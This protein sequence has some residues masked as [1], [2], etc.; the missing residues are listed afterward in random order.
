MRARGPVFRRDSI[1]SLEAACESGLATVGRQ[2]EAAKEVLAEVRRMSGM[3]SR[4][5]NDQAWMASF[6]SA[7]LRLSNQIVFI[8]VSLARANGVK[9]VGAPSDLDRNFRIPPRR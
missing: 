4:R 8:P 6:D 2:I 1:H 9:P 3:L 7:L 5:S